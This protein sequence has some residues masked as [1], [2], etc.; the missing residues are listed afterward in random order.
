MKR[1]RCGFFGFTLIELLIVIAIL[2]ILAL[3]VLIA[4]NPAK[5]QNEAKDS[6]VK[7]DI[8]QI[9]TGLQAYF[10]SS[11][12]GSGTY[13]TS[14]DKLATNKDIIRVPTSP[15]GGSYSYDV[16]PAGCLGTLSSPCTDAKLSY[17]LYAPQ[18]VGDVWCFQS[19]AGK[20]Q[21][22][23]PASCTP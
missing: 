2:G 9:A 11:D 22:I 18:T 13:P 16:S 23:A 4:I 1:T 14:L 7:T 12:Q 21:E 5:R 17:F 6:Q 19:S 15:S 8:G 3:V 20:A 10:T